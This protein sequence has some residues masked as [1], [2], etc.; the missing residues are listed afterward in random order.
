MAQEVFPSVWNSPGVSS[1]LPCRLSLEPGGGALVGT[2]GWG[3]LWMSGPS[4]QSGPCCYSHTFD[5]CQTPTPQ[6]QFMCHYYKVSLPTQLGSVTQVKHGQ[7]T[8][9]GTN[10][11]AHGWACP[12]A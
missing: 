6:P 9:L 1:C 12:L 7:K 11:L 3:I 4:T 10:K 8:T 5:L 2:G